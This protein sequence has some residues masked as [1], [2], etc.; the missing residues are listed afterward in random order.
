MSSRIPTHCRLLI[1]SAIGLLGGCAGPSVFSPGTGSPKEIPIAALRSADYAGS[2]TPLD[3]LDRSI[4]AAGADP[5]KVASLCSAMVRALQQPEAS[6][7]AK[8]ALCQRLGRLLS[9]QSADAQTLR[10][11]GAMLVDPHQVDIARLALEPVPGPAVDAVFVRTLQASNGAVRLALVQSVGHRRIAAAVP[12]LAGLLRDPDAPTANAAANA[13]GWIAT[14]AAL[15]ELERAPAPDSQVVAEARL[16]CI[17]RLSGP[18]GT[19]AL[20]SMAG[21]PALAGPQ[22]AAAWRALLDREPFGATRQILAAL[23]GNDAAIRPVALEAIVTVSSPDLPSALGASLA[24]CSPSIQTALVTALARKGD[25]AAVPYVLAATASPDPDVRMSALAALGMLPGNGD[26]ALWLA[27]AASAGAPEESMQ[28][29]ESLARLAGEGVGK[30]VLD[31]ARRAEPAVRRVFLEEVGLRNMTEAVPLL[32]ETRT[33]PDTSVRAAAL[34][35]LGEI[36]PASCQADLLSWAVSAREGPEETR[37]LRALTNVTLRNPD[38][39]GRSRALVEAIDHGDAAVK[40]RLLSVLPRL[41]GDDAASCAGRAAL[42][43]Q[44]DVAQAAEQSLVQWPDR[45]ALPLLVSAAEHSGVADVREASLK[46]AMRAL[47]RFRRSPAEEPSDLVGRLLASTQDPQARRRLLFLLGRGSSSGALALAG[48]LENDPLLGDEAKDAVLAIKANQSWPPKP[49]VSAA[50]E[51]A[52]NI[53][54]NDPQT[55]W[56]V[57]SNGNQW[58]QV[59]LGSVRPV[60][61]LTLD[62]AGHEGNFPAAYEVRVTD[63]PATP[64]AAL[65]S[66]SGQTDKTVIELPKGTRGR[67]VI[68]TDTAAAGTGWWSVTDLQVD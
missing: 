42:L 37:A 36:A 66:G 7:A 51:Q 49:K 29:R 17:G 65:A 16:R 54:D 28:A 34:R 9:E 62:Q 19:Q 57:Q 21:D 1:A 47:E 33:D 64:G 22:R 5:A 3:E 45:A 67:Y 40:V 6:F 55:A 11:L 50:Q 60:R 10:V 63:D 30:A 20:R 25:A 8:Q 13:L 27:A 31:G 52:G 39:A 15:A 46:G 58:L 56:E 61:R 53:F 12:L 26:V 38:V 44:A 59:D 35:A 32:L 41:G 43:P 14:P 68:I 18:D 24:S 4:S 48:S 23:S 2:Q